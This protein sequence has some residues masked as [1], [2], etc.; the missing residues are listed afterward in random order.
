MAEAGTRSRGSVAPFIHTL[1]QMLESEAAL[2]WTAD[3]RSFQILDMAAFTHDVLPQYFN[4]NKYA[5]FQRQLNYFGFR[6]RTKRYSRICTF[7][8]PDF[9]R[10]EHARRQLIVRQK[11]GKG[12]GAT[13]TDLDLDKDWDVQLVA[14]YI[15][16]CFGQASTG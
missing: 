8:N 1:G 14:A 12:G 4:H 15:E 9:T 16:D 7:T 5:S 13:T 2:Q 10:D 3:G 6:K 11:A